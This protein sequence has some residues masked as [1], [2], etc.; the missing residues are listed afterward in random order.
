MYSSLAVLC[1]SA[2]Y[3]CIMLSTASCVNHPIQIEVVFYDVSILALFDLVFFKQLLC[4]SAVQK[5]PFTIPE[6]VQASPCRST[7]GILYTGK[8]VC[9]KSEAYS[10]PLEK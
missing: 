10:V 6:L 9:C 1:V 8:T 2:N 3:N 7:D 4:P 5:L